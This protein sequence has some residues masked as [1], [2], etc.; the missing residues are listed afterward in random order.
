MFEDYSRDC[1]FSPNLFFFGRIFQWLSNCHRLFPSLK[2]DNQYNYFRDPES[3]IVI[4]VLVPTN[5]LF[6]QIFTIAKGMQF[7]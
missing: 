5:C 2:V 6:N 7:A 3:W 1:N 4:N